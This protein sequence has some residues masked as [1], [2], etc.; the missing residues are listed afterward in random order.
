MIAIN[1]HP[2]VVTLFDPEWEKLGVRVSFLLLYKT[3]PVISGNKWYKLKLN[4]EAAKREGKTT[5]LTFGGAY[6]NHIHA[7]AG[8]CNALGFKSI[9]I[10][11]GERVEPLNKTL[12]DAE[13]NG[14][15]LVFINRTHYREKNDKNFIEGLKDRFGD[16]YLVPEGGSNA[17]GVEGCMDILN[18]IS[19]NYDYYCVGCGTGATLAGISLSIPPSAKALGFSALKGGDFL[20]DSVRS[21]RQWIGWKDK[22]EIMTVSENFS[23]ITDFH[24]G[25]FAKKTQALIDFTAAFEGRHGIPLDL[26]YTG[27]LVFGIDSMIKNKDFRPGSR[28]LLVHTGGLQGKA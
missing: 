21:M 11:R 18:G 12:K 10:I 26:V 15:E 13:G 23:I 9:G 17:L 24:F 8:A 22:E 3:H 25:G 27:K 2:E 14:M 20:V 16:F 7:A 1:E 4:L 19:D 6:S 5:I 28:L